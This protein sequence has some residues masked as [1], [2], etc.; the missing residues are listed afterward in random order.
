M[1][2]GSSGRKLKEALLGS[3]VFLGPSFILAVQMS[4]KGFTNSFYVGG[5]TGLALLWVVVLALVFKFSIVDGLARFTLARGDSI[6][7]GL[8]S[9][10]GPRNWGVWAVIIVY[11]IELM[12]Y[13]SMAMLAGSILGELM[14]GEQS[15]QVLA[16]SVVL[17][18]LVMLLWRSMG[19][20]EKVVY[21][22]VGTVA[23][24]ML[25][26]FTGTVVTGPLFAP[27]VSYSDPSITQGLVLLLGSGSGLSL[28]LY[29]VWV[30]E[31]IKKVPVGMSKKDALTGL[32]TGMVIA[33]SITGL[34]SVVI[35]VVAA[36]AGTA[37]VADLVGVEISSLPFVAPVFILSVGSLMFG[38]V[39]LG[40]DG[41]AK[42]IGSMLRQTGL[43]SMD[44]G[45]LYRVLVIGFTVILLA[46]ILLGEPYGLLLFI[47][48]ISSTMFAMVGFSLIYLN[49]KLQPPYRAG[50][51]WMVLTAV[52]S[53]AF[54]AIALIKEQTMLEFGF[55]MLLRLVAV[56][57][58][59]YI[60]VRSGALR[61]MVANVNNAKGMVAMVAM[62]GAISV[63]GTV[64]GVEYE[65]A[66][67][68][69]RDLGP[70]MAGVLGGPLVGTLVGLLGGG[71]RYSMGGWTSAAC[72][73]ATVSSGLV[74][75]LFS[76][77]WKG[78]LSYLRLS[79]LGLLAEGMHLFLYFPLLTLGHQL[80]E[81]LD[82]LRHITVPM[83]VTCLVG[84]MIFYYVLERWGLGDVDR[85]PMAQ[86]RANDDAGDR[87]LKG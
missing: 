34:F 66:V 28:L 41:R 31:K 1:V 52:G 76:R 85:K 13:A 80:S 78:R 81:I 35:M 2:G 25:Y 61:W 75:G 32:K 39:F 37:S 70:I 50:W 43:I 6:F 30:S 71:L 77:Y 46:T 27:A 67:I 12:A 87:A 48:S 72:F 20:L 68:N 8:P 18:A 63:F 59:L 26:S 42:A 21:V 11:V 79:F 62:F 69:F 55:P 83:M 15:A 3:L 29:S 84:L 38:I 57:L 44:K 36:A 9:L 73:V 7:S 47:S 86:G 4:G 51:A 58:A 19:F 33:F 74:S 54:L 22:I 14:P 64:G 65:G 17:V 49:T 82:V 24:L 40:M 60:M 45:T 5:S 56:A 10:P 23:V 16:V 53:S